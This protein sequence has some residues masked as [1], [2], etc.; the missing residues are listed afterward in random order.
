M[1][2]DKPRAFQ[3]EAVV[4]HQAGGPGG[5]FCYLATFGEAREWIAGWPDAVEAHITRVP[6]ERK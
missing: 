5:I 6:I 2:A 4:R 3:F 1:E